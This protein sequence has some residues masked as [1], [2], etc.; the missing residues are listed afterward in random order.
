MIRHWPE[1]AWLVVPKGS[2]LYGTNTS[3]RDTDYRGIIPATRDM[4][5]GIRK[6]ELNVQMI[7]EML[8]T[9]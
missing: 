2:Q 5:V 3:D 4:L 9:T 1:N 6:Y 8:F 7:Y